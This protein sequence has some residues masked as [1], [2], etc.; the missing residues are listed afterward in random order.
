MDQILYPYY[1]KDIDEGKIKRHEA[2]ELLEEL[3]L[4]VMSQNIRPES[5]LIGN[6]YHRF[7]GS[8]PITLG[9]K[10]SDG[11]DAT[12]DLTYLFIEA[13]QNSRAVTNISVRVHDNTPDDVLFTV[14]DALHAG[15]SN[16]SLFNDE[17]NIG[18]MRKRGISEEDSHDYAVMGC[19]ECCI[20]GKTGSMSANALLLTRLLDVAMRNGNASTLLGKIKDVAPKFGDPD[21]CESFEE[22]LDIVLKHGKDQ[23]K[24]L[25]ELSNFKDK[26]YAENLPAPYISAFM[27]GCLQ[28]K[29]DIT[30][31]GAIYDLTGI[32]FINS[33]ANIT[34]SLYAIK[35]IIFEKKL[36]TFKELLKAIDTNFRDHK[37]L[38]R[39]ILSLSDKFW[40][41]GFEEVDELARKI[42]TTLF[43]ET[44]QYKNFRG[45][46]IV[47]YSISM[48]THTI[49]G[50][51]SIASPDGRKAATPY[52]ASCNCSNVEQHGETA[53]M[54]SIAK[55]DFEHVLGCAVNMKFHPTAVGKTK[56]KRKKWIALLR[57]YFK[58]G[59]SQLQPTVVSGE[60]L[61]AAQ[62]NPDQYRNI[63]VKVGGYSAYFTEL[64]IEIQK[65]VIAR[66]EH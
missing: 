7:L 27:D 29:K 61:Q 19:V 21:E 37:E 25:V 24:K 17:I 15:S 60:I 1:K 36:I 16:I 53:V 62:Q 47:P 28:K 49:D 55:L 18:A 6:F 64:G 54:R 23:T 11:T 22:F 41:N 34:D 56:A 14:A 2:S 20:P 63:I 5:N 42:S 26:I 8:T 35:K 50:R 32:S 10:N 38:H 65:E 12:N 59:G 9:G 13:A 45:G 66:T 40:G 30:R 3:L 57:T 31:G 46:P 4:K 39:E 52:A 51:I 44:Y 43:E 58:I 48:T 33:I